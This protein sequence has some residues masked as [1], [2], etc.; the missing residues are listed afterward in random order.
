MSEP[1][2]LEVRNLDVDFTGRS[3]EGLLRRKTTVHAVRN[4]SFS[5]QAGQTVGLVGESGSGKSTIGR[6]ILQL[7]KP[8]RGDVYFHGAMVSGLKGAD[9]KP[10]RRS[11]QVVFQDPYSSLNPSKTIQSTL[12]E[13]LGAGNFPSTGEREGRIKELLELVGLGPDAASRYPHEFSGGQR[14]RIA[15]ARALAVEPSLIVCDEAVSALDVSTQAQVLEVLERVQS[16]SGVALLFISHDLSV[17]RYLSD[18]VIV[19]YQGSIMEMG[20]PDRLYS[21]PAHPYTATLVD[22][23]PEPNPKRQRLRRER[24]SDPNLPRF[25]TSRSAVGCPFAPRCPWAFDPCHELTPA[26]SP[27]DNGGDAACHLQDLGP[28]LDGKTLALMPADV[29]R[30]H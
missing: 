25:E 15:I 2:L 21:D 12:S 20:P 22:A 27:I 19:L 29:C 16:V 8:T 28:Q 11:V 30:G 7:V 18:E 5:V 10:F 24:L 4:V 23:V 13:A 3:S 9:L 17:V 1:P 14:Q 6:A 26:S